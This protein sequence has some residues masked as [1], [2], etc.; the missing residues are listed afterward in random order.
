MHLLKG[1]PM[2][3]RRPLGF[4]LLEMMIVVLIGAILAVLALPSFRT[5]FASNALTSASN[6][7]LVAFNV[8]REEA[9]KRDT[10]VR[11]DPV[12]CNGVASW[13]NGGFVWVPVNPTTDTPPAA[14][15]TAGNP[16]PIISGAPTASAGACGSSSNKVIATPS[17]AAMTVCYTGAGRVNLNTS[18]AACSTSSGTANTALDSGTT[19]YSIKFCDSTLVVRKGPTMNLSLSG[20]VSI[21]P[22]IAYTTC[23]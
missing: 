11:V 1:E 15:N 18:G 4:S 12:S 23:P 17:V 16:L 19:A 8:A 3:M 21:Q 13:A 5:Y 22:N 20:R 9:I 10:Y 7:A 6:G 14:P 2:N